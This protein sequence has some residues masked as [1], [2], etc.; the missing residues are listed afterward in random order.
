M[1]DD[2]HDPQHHLAG[3]LRTLARHRLRGGG[4]DHVHPDRHHPVRDRAFR[5]GRTLWPFGRTVVPKPGAGAG[6]L[7]G[8][9]LWFLLAG[10]WMAIAHVV[11]GLALPD[12]HRHPARVA[13]FK[14]AAVAIAPLGKDIVPTDD[15]RAFYR[16]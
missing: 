7:V 11:T 5:L 12:H 6:S 13:D 3:A 9:V 16:A 10:L 14:L 15:P 1:L 4:R 8:N 2:A